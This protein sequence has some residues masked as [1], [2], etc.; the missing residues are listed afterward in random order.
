[1]NTTDTKPLT[2]HPKVRTIHQQRL[3]YVYVCF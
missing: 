1:M 2:A 3:A